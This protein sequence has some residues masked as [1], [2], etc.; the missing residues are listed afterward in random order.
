MKTETK[1]KEKIILAFSGGLDTSFCVAY[2]IEKGFCVYTL[3]VDTGGFT[4]KE[5]T[6]IAEQS[7]KLGATKHIYLDSKKEL[8][9]K[10]ISYII[11]GNILR[12]SIYPLCV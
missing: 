10:F 6:Y 1:L 9:K 11:K 12:G 5:K 3:T 4:Q 2:L 7:K 8:F